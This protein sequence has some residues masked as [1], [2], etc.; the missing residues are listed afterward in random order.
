MAFGSRAIDTALELAMLEAKWLTV[1]GE[2]ADKRVDEILRKSE[3]SPEDK[4]RERLW[5]RAQEETNLTLGV[6]L[7]TFLVPYLAGFGVWR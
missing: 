5:K 6:T 1:F 7:K 2:R 3:K 4:Q